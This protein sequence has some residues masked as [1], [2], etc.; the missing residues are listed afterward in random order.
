MTRHNI[1][2]QITASFLK[3]K[4]YF[5]CPVIHTWWGKKNQVFLTFNFFFS[6]NDATA[7]AIN[8]TS[9][10]SFQNLSWQG[11]GSQDTSWHRNVA[12][13][14]FRL[15]LDIDLDLCTKHWHHCVKWL[16]AYCRVYDQDCT[17]TWI[18]SLSWG[19]LLALA[20]NVREQRWTK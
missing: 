12:I 13:V 18:K 15:L 20:F 10:I 9:H 17:V 1:C 4:L 5:V 14:P 7:L 11:K 2:W 8:A 16:S 6:S 19:R 3:E